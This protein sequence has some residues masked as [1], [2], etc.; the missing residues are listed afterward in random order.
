MYKLKKAFNISCSHCLYDDNKEE[1][2]N[3]VLYGKCVAPHGHNYQITLYLKAEDVSETG[4]VINFNN[5]KDAFKMY[6]DIVY[7][8]HE[9]NIVKPFDNLLPT[10]ENMAKVF[11]DILKIHLPQLYAVEVEETD[12]ASAIYED[13]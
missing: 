4:M 1:A 10:A 9:L 5:V 2:V 6:I 3:T 11:Y 12:G 7:D 8:H 13:V